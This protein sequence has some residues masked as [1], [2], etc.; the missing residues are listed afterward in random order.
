M[1]G[2]L[3]IYEIIQWLFYVGCTYSLLSK[4]ALIGSTLT[5][6]IVVA[7]GHYLLPTWV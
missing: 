5:R 1:S 2:N 4:Y 7:D 3:A 6:I